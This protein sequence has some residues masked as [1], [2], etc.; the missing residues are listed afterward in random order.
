M[1]PSKA[2]LVDEFVTDLKEFPTLDEY[3]EIHRRIVE[4]QPQRTVS[5]DAGTDT[6][7]RGVIDFQYNI[8]SQSRLIP[9]LSYIKCEAEILINGSA[10]TLQDKIALSEVWLSN[11]CESVS[12]YIG[13]KSISRVDDYV[14]QTSM[15]FYRTQRTYNWLNSI[16][17]DAFYLIPAVEDRQ[18]L[19]SSNATQRLFDFQ[20]AAPAGLGF[21]GGTTYEK[22]G[23]EA[24]IVFTVLGGTDLTKFVKVGDSIKYSEDTNGIKQAAVT[25]VTFDGANAGTISI[26]SV[27]AD[28]IASTDLATSPLTLVVDDE[29]GQTELNKKN[30]V[31]VLWQP[32]L[33][34]FHNRS[35]VLGAGYYRLKIK[36]SSSKAGA[37]E[38]NGN[39]PLP[40]N[41]VMNFRKYVLV[42]TIFQDTTFNDGEYYLC[43]DEFNVQNKRLNQASSLTSHNFTIPPTTH[44]ISIFSQDGNAGAQSESNA[45]I[46]ATVFKDENNSNVDLRH[47]QLF[48]GGQT[49][50]ITLFDSSFTSTTNNLVQRYEWEMCN[51]GLSEVGGESYDSW[52][53]RG[54]LYTTQ[55]IKEKGNNSTEL[56]I[57]LDY[58]DIQGDV[59]LFVAA[60]YR[61]IVKVKVQDGFVAHVTLIES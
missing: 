30:T 38:M 27:L 26:A 51:T 23:G 15:L 32:P 37:F 3:G 29:L 35:L 20:I 61:N 53:Q 48:Y 57:Q 10:P 46:P 17:K 60:M 49:K 39:F 33:G 8:Q 40:A 13:N 50:P 16:G 45:G 41:T 21:P 7:S 52:L 44:M 59:E 25:G 36:P 28:E 2:S 47:I 31:Q 19:I 34:I 12:F 54:I 5:A 58:G 43:L 9:S 1:N 56:A 18:N 42:N 55:F 22:T 6:F 14:G 24:E 11:L 4:V